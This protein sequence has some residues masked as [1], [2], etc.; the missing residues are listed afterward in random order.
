M[1]GAISASG[2]RGGDTSRQ[3]IAPPV[4]DA[5]HRPDPPAHIVRLEWCRRADAFSHLPGERERGLAVERRPDET[6]WSHEQRRLLFDGLR[7]FVIVRVFHVEPA[8]EPRIRRPA[9][10]VHIPVLHGRGLKRHTI[11]RA[12]QSVDM[13]VL[14]E[15]IERVRHVLR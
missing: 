4:V 15:E 8:V 11:A 12:E 1:F 7:C 3:R 6:G 5:E 10:F 13:L 14:V 9:H 2:D